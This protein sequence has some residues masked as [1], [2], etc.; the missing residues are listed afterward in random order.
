M[1]LTTDQSL[2]L[3]WFTFKVIKIESEMLLKVAS[4]HRRCFNLK[5]ACQE[6]KRVLHL[7]T[8]Q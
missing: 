6:T 3:Q 1:L 4:T 2:Q 7:D 5:R 8:Q